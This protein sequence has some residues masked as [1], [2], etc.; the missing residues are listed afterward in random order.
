MMKA[1]AFMRYNG[2]REKNI[3]LVNLHAPNDDNPNFFNTLFTHF[4]DFHC[5]EIIIGG[6]LV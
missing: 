4:L 2:K 5:E 1:G 6:D 3:T